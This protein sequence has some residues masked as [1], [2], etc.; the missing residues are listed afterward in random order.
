MDL[1]VPEGGISGPQSRDL[2]LDLVNEANLL[3]KVVWAV[4]PAVHT[5][6][7]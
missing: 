4:P 6:S 3:S 5:S 2:H 1:L 7:R